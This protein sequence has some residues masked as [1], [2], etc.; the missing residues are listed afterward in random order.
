MYIVKYILPT[1]IDVFSTRNP[2]FVLRNKQFRKTQ[3]NVP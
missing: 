3:P 1:E 2:C